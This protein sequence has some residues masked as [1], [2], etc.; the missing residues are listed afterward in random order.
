MPGASLR[1]HVK[2]RGVVGKRGHIQRNQPLLAHSVHPFFFISLPVCL[3]LLSSLPQA[4]SSSSTAGMIFG[5]EALHSQS[6]LVFHC[7]PQ[8]LVLMGQWE[9]GCTMEEGAR[10]GKR[11]QM[12]K[13]I[14]LARW[15]EGS[16]KER[17]KRTQ[18]P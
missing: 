18:D 13:E 7:V 3:F 5:Q 1:Q 4:R 2:K 6:V 8:G 14:Y 11:V 15:R 12:S 10:K 16:C 9:E 17:G